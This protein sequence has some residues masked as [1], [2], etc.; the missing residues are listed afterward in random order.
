M[1]TLCR[2]WW[3]RMLVL[4]PSRFFNKTFLVV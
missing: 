2:F 4:P 3:R 1:R